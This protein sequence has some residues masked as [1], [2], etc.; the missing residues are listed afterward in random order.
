MVTSPEPDD[1]RVVPHLQAPSDTGEGGALP[2]APA[3]AATWSAQSARRAW[4]GV[5]GGDAAAQAGGFLDRLADAAV[6]DLAEAVGYLRG[7]VAA[8]SAYGAWIFDFDG[9]LADSED[10]IVRATQAVLRGCGV[11]VDDAWV[12]AVPMSAPGELRARALRELGVALRWTDERLVREGF[13]FWLAHGDQ[14]QPVRPV[15]ALAKAARRKGLPLAVASANHSRLVSAGLAA[16]GLEGVF[17]AVV[18]RDQVLVPKPDPEVFLRAAHLL[19]VAPQGCL[20]F[21]N[22]DTG[23]AAAKAAGMDVVDVRTWP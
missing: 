6:G 19:K 3:P 5:P 13:A 14:L 18:G 9:T 2:A 10:M 22:T 11:V 15:V 23:I 12:R 1:A 16:L 17:T 8:G 21:E 4:S 7:S 20:A